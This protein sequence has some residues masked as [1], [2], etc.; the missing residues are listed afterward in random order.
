MR[1]LLATDSGRFTIIASRAYCAASLIIRVWNSRSRGEDIEVISVISRICLGYS[2]YS[3]CRTTS[4][5]IGR[6]LAGTGKL[7]AISTTS[8][9]W[10]EMPFEDKTS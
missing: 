7:R 4:V 8:G 5:G 1:N 2:A 9:A 3:S 6:C 10:S